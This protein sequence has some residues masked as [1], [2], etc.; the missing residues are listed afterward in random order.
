MYV[1]ADPLAQKNPRFRRRKASLTHRILPERIAFRLQCNCQNGLIPTKW[2]GMASDVIGPTIINPPDFAALVD[3]LVCPRDLVA[4]W[5]ISV[6]RRR[7]GGK[8]GEI[9]CN[10]IR[11]SASRRARLSADGTRFEHLRVIKVTV[12]RIPSRGDV[13]TMGQHTEVGN[14]PHPVTWYQNRKSHRNRN[15][16]NRAALKRYYRFG[17]GFKKAVGEMPRKEIGGLERATTTPATHDMPH[18]VGECH[19]GP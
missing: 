16:Q 12:A 9:R 1:T 4:R 3:R 6:M 17:I 8:T 2:R 15:P 10:R 13:G 7:P 5:R 19:D 18:F 14:K 11:G